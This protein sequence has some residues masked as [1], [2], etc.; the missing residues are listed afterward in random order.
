M[1]DSR[2]LLIIYLLIRRLS[3]F[4]HYYYLT[5]YVERLHT[6][7]RAVVPMQRPPDLDMACALVLL[8][9]EV[10]DDIAIKQK[11]MPPTRMAE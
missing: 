7:I 1:T 10:V 11:R 2:W 9:E 5:Q 6:D 4:N 8:Q 3:I